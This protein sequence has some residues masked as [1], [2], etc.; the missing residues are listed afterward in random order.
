MATGSKDGTVAISDERMKKRVGIYSIHKQE[1]C[2]L[3]WNEDGS[4]LA[5]GSNDKTIGIFDI[6]KFKELIKLKFHSA[7][8]KA[9]DWC[10]QK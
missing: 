3:K 9:L 7:A 6:R 1:V 8:I 2:G 5:T 10:P 4:M